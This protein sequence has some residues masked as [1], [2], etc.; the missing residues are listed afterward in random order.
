MQHRYTAF[1]FGLHF[2]VAR[3]WERKL[4]KLVIVMRLNNA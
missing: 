2:R 4:A 1:E 3:R